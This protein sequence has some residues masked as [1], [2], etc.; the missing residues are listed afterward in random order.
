MGDK[1]E[2]NNPEIIKLYYQKRYGKDF[3]NHLDK[4]SNIDLKNFNKWEHV[5]TGKEPTQAFTSKKTIENHLNKKYK[6]NEPLIHSAYRSNALSK[7]EMA[8][9]NEFGVSMAKVIS[10]TTPYYKSSTWEGLQSENDMNVFYFSSPSRNE[11]VFQYGKNPVVPRELADEYN[12]ER[13][14][15]SKIPTI[16]HDADQYIY[17]VN[18]PKDFK[19]VAIEQDANSLP[20]FF[21][22]LQM[23]EA[24]HIQAS[25]RLSIDSPKP[26]MP[27]SKWALNPA[28]KKPK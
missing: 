9:I 18:L 4:L 16:F 3:S 27:K 26:N 12:S 20:K 10:W 19:K 24:S 17:R 8:A 1:Q 23:I 28:Y 14:L 11:D 5:I 7:S 15:F 13:K 21:I 22:P 25:H 6:M 2:I